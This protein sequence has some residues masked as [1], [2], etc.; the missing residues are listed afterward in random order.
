MQ[1]LHNFT[2]ITLDPRTKTWGEANL[3]VTLFTFFKL[4]AVKHEEKQLERVKLMYGVIL[5]KRI[6]FYLSVLDQ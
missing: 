1:F 5:Q 6:A 4:H 3:S 2:L